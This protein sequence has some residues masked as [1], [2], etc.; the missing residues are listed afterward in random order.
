[1]TAAIG[2]HRRN[3]RIGIGWPILFKRP[4][5]LTRSVLAPATARDRRIGGNRLGL[6]IT[7]RRHNPAPSGGKEIGP[8]PTDRGKGRGKCSLLTDAL[9][10]ALTVAIDGENRHGMKLVK[11]TLEVLKRGWPRP[12][13]ALRRQMA[14]SGYSILITSAPRPAEVWVLYSPRMTVKGRHANCLKHASCIVTLLRK[15]MVRRKL[16]RKFEKRA[17][18]KLPGR[19]FSRSRPSPSVYGRKFCCGARKVSAFVGSPT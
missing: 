4:Q 16:T 17:T 12:T 13:S 10:I 6:V 18:V 19:R 14:R 3:R 7:G 1:M 5:G 9:G 15:K 2:Q 8:D 11:L